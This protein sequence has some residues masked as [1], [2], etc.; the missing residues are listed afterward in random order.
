MKNL[1]NNVKTQE[2]K[3]G[4]IIKTN[5]SNNENNEQQ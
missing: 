4:K 3:Q 1:E 5:E 2:Q